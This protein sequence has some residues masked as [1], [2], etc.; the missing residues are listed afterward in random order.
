MPRE[1]MYLTKDVSRVR[2]GHE[3]P[4]LFDLD[5]H[6]VK[7]EANIHAKERD[8]ARVRPKTHAARI[9]R[10]LESHGMSMCYHEIFEVLRFKA[11]LSGI[12]KTSLTD[13]LGKLLE[14]GLIAVASVR[15]CDLT[16]EK[17]QH[18]QITEDGRDALKK[19]REEK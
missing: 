3:T 19:M 2:L 9:L 15:D 14:R 4:D 13:P 11:G 1:Q 12:Q 6:Q 7:A 5:G 10:C 18:Y 8:A 17:I 16:V